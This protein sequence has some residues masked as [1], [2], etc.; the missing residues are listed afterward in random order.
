MKIKLMIWKNVKILIKQ[1][2]Q[3]KMKIQKIMTL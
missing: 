2:Y 3:N 1:L